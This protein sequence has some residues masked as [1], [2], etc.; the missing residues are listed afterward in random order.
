MG[1]GFFKP[2]LPFNAPKKYWD[3]YDRDDIEITPSENIPL[4]TS[5]KYL[6]NSGEV[7]GYQLTDEILSLDQPAS[8]AYAKK[9][10]HAYYASVSYIDAQIGKV[11]N[12]LS[13][14][15]LAD[16]TVVVVWGDHGWNLGDHRVWGKHTV[17]DRSL[18]SALIVKVPQLES[19]VHT[20]NTIVETVDIYPTLLE[21][22][23]VK[24]NHKIDGSSFKEL[25]KNPDVEREEVAYSYYNKGI[26]LKTNR[27][28]LI[29]YFEQKPVYYLF[30]HQ[31][32]PNENINIAASNPE[33]IEKLL[34]LLEDGDT[35]IFE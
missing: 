9:L 15:G 30:D 24:L 4:N 28:R 13:T 25:I 18:K 27:Y 29:K 16:N 17:Y 26:S 19:T 3:L 22:C 7:N 32:D 6:H 34:P 1:V 2:H 35:G 14:A 31:K 5:K 21:L 11:L 23:Q 8:E 12:E 33:I 10:R 20:T